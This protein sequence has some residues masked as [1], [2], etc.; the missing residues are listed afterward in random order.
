[1]GH[2]A[3]FRP[4]IILFVSCLV[5]I[6]PLSSS[7]GHETS[8]LWDS[9]LQCCPG[10]SLSSAQVNR[11]SVRNFRSS[12]KTVGGTCLAPALATEG[13]ADLVEVVEFTMD[14]VV[15]GMIK[16]LLVCMRWYLATVLP[17]LPDLTTLAFSGCGR[18]AVTHTSGC[19]ACPWVMGETS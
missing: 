5:P 16:I 14:K 18:R 8:H 11:L 13:L 6:L 19:F 3:R 9:V 10:C 2:N 7:L 15:P 17:G 12:T 4:T 1:M